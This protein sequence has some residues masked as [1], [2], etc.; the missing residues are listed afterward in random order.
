MNL[1]LSTALWAHR[2]EGIE[3]CQTIASI[4]NLYPLFGTPGWEEV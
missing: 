1:F 2:K 4:S 3:K